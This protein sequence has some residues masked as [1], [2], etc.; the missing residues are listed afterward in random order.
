MLNNRLCSF[1]VCLQFINC[2]EYVLIY[3]FF[4]HFSFGYVHLEPPISS[5]WTFFTILF[6]LLAISLTLPHLHIL[7]PLRL[8]DH[9]RCVS[10]LSLKVS[11]TEK[12]TWPLLRLQYLDLSLK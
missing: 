6:V 4:C 5:K 8:G 3:K 2:R 9:G 12:Y 10:F 7:N 11:L 1:P